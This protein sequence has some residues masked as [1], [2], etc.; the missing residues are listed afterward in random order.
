VVD[1]TLDDAGNMT[2]R[3][4]GAVNDSFQYDQANRLTRAVVGLPS[5]TTSTYAYNGDGVRVSKQVS[6][7]TNA[8]TRYVWDLASSLPVLLEDGTRRYV[9]GA[10][11]AGLGL[12][13]NV[14]VSSGAVEVYHQD[15]LG[16]VREL[17][18]SQGHVT[19]IYLTDEYGV[20]STLEGPDGTPA[21]AS[22][23]PFW[24][25]GELFD[26]G[27]KRPGE[28]GLLYLRARYDASSVGRF[29]SLDAL[30]GSEAY[31]AARTAMSP[32]GQ[33]GGLRGGGRAVPRR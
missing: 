2:S 10:K 17:T 23:Q 15:H 4:G 7:Q 19:S 33:S 6:G 27:P 16:S 20:P 26:G 21:T 1:Y 22:D 8:T 28:P 5:P 12:A 9:W 24:F 32:R 30:A 13:Y 31:P 18:D 29:T 14:S 25:T 3:V 11:G